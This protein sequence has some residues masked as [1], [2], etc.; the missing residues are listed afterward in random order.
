M[1]IAILHDPQDG[2]VIA[3]KLAQS[4][5]GGEHQVWYD[6]RATQ[7]AIDVSMVNE[8]AVKRADRIVVCLTPNC[9]EV[10]SR[11]Q[12]FS[13]LAR[14]AEKPVFVWQAAQIAVPSAL[15]YL[16]PLTAY[17]DWDQS[18]TR[19]KNQL[20]TA[21][22]IEP[23][24]ADPAE[25]DPY[26]DI[27]EPRRKLLE[28]LLVRSVFNLQIW[29]DDFTE[30]GTAQAYPFS[31]SDGVTS[32]SFDDLWSKHNQQAMVTGPAA[33]GKSILLM[34]LAYQAILKR[35]SDPA[36]LIPQYIQLYPWNGEDSL[37]QGIAGLDEA[38]LFVDGLN[39][40]RADLVDETTEMPLDLRVEVWRDFLKVMPAGTP[41]VLSGVPSDYQAL[42]REF[43]TVP[44]QLEIQPLAESTHQ[45]SLGEGSHWEYVQ[46]Q[47]TLKEV[48]QRPFYLT[49]YRKL[50]E[51][52]N[53]ELDGESVYETQDALIDAYIE[54]R[55]ETTDALAT[56][57]TEE[58][59][60]S[61]ESVLWDLLT[62][63]KRREYFELWENHIQQ[64]LGRQTRVVT[65]SLIKLGLLI[66]IREGVARF[67]HSHVYRYFIFDNLAK[68]FLD[69][70]AG[71]QVKAVQAFTRYIEPE[72]QQILLTALQSD[73]VE[74][75]PLAAEALARLE[76]PESVPYLLKSYSEWTGNLQSAIV[77]AL[78]QFADKR[79]LAT[80]TQALDVSNNNDDGRAIAAWAL[81]RIGD[82]SS[83]PALQN[84]IHDE[85][86]A[87]AITAIEALGKLQA[88]DVVTDLIV[89]LD[90]MDEDIRR[91][92]VQALG[93]IGD[94]RAV[95]I[96]LNHL[97]DPEAKVRA[98]LYRT[99]Q[100]LGDVS[101]VEHLIDALDDDDPIVCQSAASSL[102]ELGAEV[103]P[104]LVSALVETDNEEI[105]YSLAQVLGQFGYQ[106]VPNLIEI[107]HHENADVRS[108]VVQAL[109][110]IGGSTALTVLLDLLDNDADLDVRIHAANA[111]GWVGDLTALDSLISH[112]D[113]EEDALVLSILQAL[114][115]LADETTIPYLEP[116]LDS[117]ND[118]ISGT[119]NEIIMNLETEDGEDL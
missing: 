81:G 7:P 40:M 89:L 22:P 91:F 116:L 93:R 78:A 15:S 110:W 20:S 50:A 113:E 19:L 106:A 12:H 74:V 21:E 79:T 46:V 36:A 77:Q 54:E 48:I 95:N 96:L 103:T 27:L 90:D 4:L 84:A 72:A 13:R 114:S 30:L 60:E 65:D 112:L 108:S 1:K 9:T 38:V 69:G 97:E 105:R 31:L 102:Q 32:G 85:D 14:L 10:T 107:V 24:S 82:Q 83:I 37:F 94:K 47:P 5:S 100:K 18:V 119:V 76:N 2:Q 87:V 8:M 3:E 115:E 42:R 92:A 35:L 88:T 51:P 66:P 71:E 80:F 64:S 25:N 39:E 17:V 98:E 70:F 29:D 52:A 99:L 11:M 45:T 41:V 56:L 16:Q 109:G 6:R 118:M 55:V 34:G 73:N 61:V 104:T 57:S 53:L 86:W 33:S 111:I 44:T 26:F 23:T 67:I 62:G 68:R 43:D 49:L 63:S 117:P 28:I 101:A 75:V 58:L 59:L